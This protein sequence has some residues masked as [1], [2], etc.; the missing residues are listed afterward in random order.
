MSPIETDDVTLAVVVSKLEGI[1]LQISDLSVKMDDRPTWQDVNR[2]QTN[3]REQ[4]EAAVK[5]RETETA[6]VVQRVSDL[7]SWQM[8]AGRLVMGTMGTAAIGAVFIFRP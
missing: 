4:L 7:E 5:Q 8:W 2:I 6:A 1:T 3:W